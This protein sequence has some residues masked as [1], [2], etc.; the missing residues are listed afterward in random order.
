MRVEVEDDLRELQ[1]DHRHLELH[2][3]HLELVRSPPPKQA[4]VG[5]ATVTCLPESGNH[6]L[7]RISLR[8]GTDPAGSPADDLPRWEPPAVGALNL[9]LDHWGGI[10][11]SIPRPKHG[12]TSVR[13]FPR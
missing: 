9:A 3:R 10:M 1:V 2:H 4:P 12:P 6:N 8:A 11:T 13:H 5:E 7:P